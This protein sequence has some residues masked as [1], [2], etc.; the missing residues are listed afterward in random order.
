LKITSL[1]SVFD[2]YRKEKEC[3]RCLKSELYKKGIET[4]QAKLN[5]YMAIKVKL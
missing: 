5:A 3:K 4:F 2:I 1:K